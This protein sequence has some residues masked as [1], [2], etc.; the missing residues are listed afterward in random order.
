[1]GKYNPDYGLGGGGSGS[2]LDVS[3][4]MVLAEISGVSSPN[5]SP[6]GEIIISAVPEPSTLAL[7]AMSV[8]SVLLF[9]RRR[10]S[11]SGGYL[12]ITSILL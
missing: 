8:I 10:M 12:A 2:T 7:A 9:G 3:A 6:N 11:V 1:M 5:G 4:I